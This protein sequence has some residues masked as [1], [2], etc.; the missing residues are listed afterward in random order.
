[1]SEKEQICLDLEAQINSFEVE[2]AQSDNH[3]SK[4]SFDSHVDESQTDDTFLSSFHD[5]LLPLP[6]YHD[7]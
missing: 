2:Q 4:L 6:S 3:I 7:Q 1:L 5:M